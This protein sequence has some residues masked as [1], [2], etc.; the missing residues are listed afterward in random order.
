M[1]DRE[2]QRQEF[3]KKQEKGREHEAE[4]CFPSSLLV[5]LTDHSGLSS[6]SG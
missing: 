6:R 2:S 1:E 3:L 5:R 4:N